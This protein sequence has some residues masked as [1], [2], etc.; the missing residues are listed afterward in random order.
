MSNPKE[1]ILLKFGNVLL[2][3]KEKLEMVSKKNSTETGTYTVYHSLVHVGSSLPVLIAVLADP[4][5]DKPSAK[6]KDIDFKSFHVRTY[7]NWSD[8]EDLGFSDLPDDLQTLS[9]IPEDVEEF[10]MTAFRETDDSRSYKFEDEKSGIVTLFTHRTIQNHTSHGLPFKA[11]FLGWMG[12]CN[13]V[14]QS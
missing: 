2:Q 5:F 11:R 13:F 14:Y 1:L 7:K 12:E 6:V 10:E 8:F 3:R 9:D 4:T